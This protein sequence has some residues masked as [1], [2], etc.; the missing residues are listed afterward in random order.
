MST[1]SRWRLVV[2]AGCLLLPSVLAGQSRE[3]RSAVADASDLDEDGQ[4]ARLPTLPNGMTV[5]MIREGDSLFRGKAGCVTCHG[6]EGGGM[7]AS[8][9]GITAGLHFVPAQW[10]PID[11]LVRAGIPEPATRTPVAMPPRGAQ[12]NLTDEESRRVAA[13]V[14]AISQVKG[15]PW[16]GGHREHGPP[17]ASQ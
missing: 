5:A 2:L 10:G 6:A 11:S 3:S 8:G 4:A 15:E 9:S 17:A 7:P 1:A 16:P 12:S 13:Y 14:W